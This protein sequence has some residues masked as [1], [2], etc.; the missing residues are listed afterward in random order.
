MADYPNQYIDKLD[1]ACTK[2]A[3]PLI[4]FFVLDLVVVALALYVVGM[5]ANSLG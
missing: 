4:G 1:A 2:E 5:I 3:W